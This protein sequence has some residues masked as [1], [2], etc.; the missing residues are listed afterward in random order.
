MPDLAES[1]ITP[2]V[3]LIYL[4]TLKWYLALALLIPFILVLLAQTWMFKDYEKNANMY[5]DLKKKLH[6]TIIEYVHGIKIF[7]AFNL[8]AKT[9][10]NYANVV[11]E[12]LSA[13][14]QMCDSSIKSYTI[15]MCIIDSSPFL[16]VIPIGGFLFLQH[17][18]TGSNFLMFL[19]L[20]SV[21]LTSFVKLGMLGGNLAMLLKGAENVRSILETKEQ[22]SGEIDLSKKEAES[23]IQFRNVNFK[24]EEKYVIKD[25]S[26]SLK[27]GSVTALVGPSGSGKTTLGA[28]V[29]RFYD[30]EEGGIFIGKKNINDYTIESLLMQTS[31]VF[32]DV[33]ILHDT[34]LNNVNLG[35][36]KTKEEVIEACKK[37]QIHPL[38]ESL[39]DGYE[40][41]IGEGSGIKLSGGEMQRLSIARAFLKDAPI[42]VLDEIT[43]YSDIENEKEI[44]KALQTLL[45]GKTSII[46]A[47]RL[48]TIKNADNIVVLNEGK[49]AEEWTHEVLL[50]KDGMYKRMWERE[51][52]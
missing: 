25:L 34:V 11:N 37:S 1:I 22:K 48:Y 32:Q 42:V 24:Y 19:L 20:G 33:F 49:I 45:K 9:F 18:L 29:G 15:G 36:G 47:H 43:S 30:V 31:F 23:D 21:F 50:A 35:L 10:K 39:K 12:Y 5:N 27:K 4:L 40:T 46:I 13:W 3:I 2:L 28:L 38:I 16:I 51:V 7:K 6:T 14:V 26:L 17:N 52:A 41:V 8:T 44:Q